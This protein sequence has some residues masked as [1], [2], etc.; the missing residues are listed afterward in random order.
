MKSYDLWDYSIEIDK[1]ATSDWYE[2]SEGWGCEC[3]DCRNFLELI[4]QKRLPSEVAE[5]LALFGILME[6]PTYVCEMCPTKLGHLYQFNYRVKGCIRNDPHP[7]DSV[8]LHWG[9]C[10][11]GHDPYPYGAPDF[12]EPH[13]DLIFFVDLPWILQE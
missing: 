5:L 11:C 10:S 13:F 7:N 8:Q 1:S 12:P 2:K 3:G 9:S 6:K 4:K